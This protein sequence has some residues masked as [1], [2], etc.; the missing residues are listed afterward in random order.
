MHG[1]NQP[2][3]GSV[4]KVLLENRPVTALLSV[5]V[6]FVIAVG[7]ST[8]PPPHSPK[9]SQKEINA[10]FDHQ[11]PERGTLSEYQMQDMVMD[12]ADLY[13]MELWQAFDEILRS[14]VSRELRIAA[15]YGKVLF[16]TAAM[17]IA[18]GQYPAAN[19]LDMIVHVSLMRYA[20]EKYWVPQVYHKQGACLKEVYERL[21][22]RVWK[23]SEIV[24]TKPQQDQLRQLI[25]E[26]IQANPGQYYVSEVRL[27]DFVEMGRMHPTAAARE[28]TGLLN[29][30]ERALASVDRTLLLSERAMFYLERLPRT[31]TMQTELVMAQLAT[32][33]EIDTLIANTSRLATVAEELPGQVNEMRQDTITELTGWLE[34]ER[35]KLFADLISQENRLKG[36]LSEVRKSLEAGSELTDKI[37]TTVRMVDPLYRMFNAN[38][39]KDSPTEP[40]DYIAVLDR[41]IAAIDRLDALLAHASPLL[42]PEGQPLNTAALKDTLNLVENQTQRLMDSAFRLGAYLIGIFLIGLLAVLI[43]YR[44]VSA[45]ISRRAKPRPG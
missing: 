23:M 39:A 10:V 8:S 22:P 16:G 1:E 33:P 3:K 44:S 6:C 34:I 21:E 15:Q 27:S 36:L 41:S 35:Q 13:V 4:F 24:L 32:M 25:Q 7:C 30:V 11:K 2:E 20:V 43:I 5:I 18:A 29:D 42:G 14:D 17:G 12:F 31:L 40:V 9:T 19:L 26:W 37:N 45:R 28:A 38:N